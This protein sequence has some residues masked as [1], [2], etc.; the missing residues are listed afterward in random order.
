MKF[1]YEFE[2]EI[3]HI[4]LRVLDTIEIKGVVNAQALI[5]AHDAL[6]TD[7]F[8]AEIKKRTEEEEKAKK[9]EEPK[10]KK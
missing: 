4:L 3:I 5:K 2:E 9:E 1:K 8:V 7:E 10:E 6:V